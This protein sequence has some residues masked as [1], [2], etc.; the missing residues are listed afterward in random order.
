[1]NKKSL[2]LTVIIVAVTFVFTVVPAFSAQKASMHDIKQYIIKCSTEM[3]VEPEIALSIAKQETGFCQEKRSRMGAVGVF[4]LMPSTAR[5]FGYNPY[6]YQSNIKCGIAYYK[7][8]KRMF[9]SD[10]VALAAY[11]AGP[12]NVK[13]YGGIPPFAETRNF[14]RNV[15]KYYDEYKTNPDPTVA[16]ML[17]AV[18]A[19]KEDQKVLAE[20]EHREMLTLFMLNQAI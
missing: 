14:V 7:Q 16:T 13:K 19:P 6:Q 8:M 12:G 17:A 10:A 9:K 11:N 1:M 20:K 3:G 18:K 2:L 5:R 4:Q 15:M